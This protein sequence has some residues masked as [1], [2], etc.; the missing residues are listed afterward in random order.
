MYWIRAAVKR[1]QLY[2]SRVIQIPQRLHENSKRIEVC[3]K[4]LTEA[5]D[6]PPTVS[7]ISNVLGMTT[8]Q[9]ERCDTA[10]AQRISSLDQQIVNRNKPMSTDRG[11]ESLHSIIASKTDDDETQKIDLIHLR[12]DLLKALNIHLTQEEASIITLR[13]G[14]DEEYASSKKAGRTIS[15]VGDI[16][17]L[18]PDKVRRIILRSLK[19]LRISIGDDFELYNQEFST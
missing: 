6:R 1:D 11:M 10:M 7:E 19:K 8:A 17:G 4:E 14:M 2:Q 18:K 13:F 3:R 9:I 16:T 5:L 15:E 12:E